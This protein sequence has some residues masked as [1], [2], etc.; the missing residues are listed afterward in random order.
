MSDIDDSGTEEKELQ[1]LRLKNSFVN[2]TLLQRDRILASRTF[3]LVH[4]VTRD[5]LSFLLRKKLL[6]RSHEIKETTLG[7]FVWRDRTFDPLTTTKVRVGAGALRN[8][9]TR[10]YATEGQNDPIEI[11][12]PDRTYVPDIDDRRTYI[13][14][15]DFLNWNH[16]G[17][18]EYL[19]QALPAEILQSLNQIPWVRANRNQ[20]PTVGAPR[21]RYCL[22]GIL[23]SS[24]GFVW[25]L[26]SLASLQTGKMIYWR[27]FEGLRDDAIKLAHEIAG[28][29]IYALRPDVDT[30]TPPKSDQPHPAA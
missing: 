30:S 2:E 5:L 23:Q 4:Q 13:D 14:V 27:S 22:K 19:C 15:T 17:A 1:E 18:E 3:K 12:I 21:L 28:H 25:L 16:A 6:G 10:Y 8:R 7:I 9:L 26:I 24:D 20:G 29:I 11:T